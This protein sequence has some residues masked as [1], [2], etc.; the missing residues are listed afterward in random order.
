L[1]IYV[2]DF[3]KCDKMYENGH[4]FTI[5][6]WMRSSNYYHLTYDMLLPL[7]AQWYYRQLSAADVLFMPTVESSRLQV[8]LITKDYILKILSQNIGNY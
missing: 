1:Y 4:A 8:I 2:Q 5:F 7:Y 6:Y 3:F